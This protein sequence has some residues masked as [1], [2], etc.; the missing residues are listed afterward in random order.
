MKGVELVLT[1]QCDRLD[2]R[3]QSQFPASSL[4]NMQWTRAFSSDHL[5]FSS[6][7]PHTA[8]AHCITRRYA[9][10]IS[11]SSGGGGGGEAERPHTSVV[12]VHYKLTTPHTPGGGYPTLP[13]N[14]TDLLDED[15][16]TSSSNMLYNDPS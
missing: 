4:P 5:T 10:S 9:D 1:A 14:R 12:S 6:P 2:A 3:T 16:S 7:S 11:E 13:H 15:V 8:C